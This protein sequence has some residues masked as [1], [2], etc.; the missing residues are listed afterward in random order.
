MSSLIEKIIRKLERLDEYQ[1]Y[2]KEIS[3]YKQ[4]E[5]VRNYKI[6]GLAERYLQLSIEIVLDV[7]KLILLYKNFPKP[8]SNHEVFEILYKESVIGK[9]LF[10]RLRGISGFRNILVHD[11]E[12]IDLKIVYSKL[13]NNCKDFHD[14]K[15]AVIKKLNID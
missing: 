10:E 9:S 6:F 5:F 13:K 1:K 3:K 8:D 14:F 7:S 15:K 11:Y 12:K 2:L 4:E